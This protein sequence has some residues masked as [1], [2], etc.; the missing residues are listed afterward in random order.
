MIRLVRPGKQ[1][2][3]YLRILPLLVVLL[4]ANSETRQLVNG[5]LEQ[6]LLPLHCSPSECIALNPAHADAL[7]PGL[8]FQPLPGAEAPPSASNL[9]GLM[10]LLDPVRGFTRPFPA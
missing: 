1:A 9:V 2:R 10:V 5:A 4:W 3:L 7:W 8:A 6:I